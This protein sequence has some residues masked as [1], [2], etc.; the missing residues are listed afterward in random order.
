MSLKVAVVGTGN[1]ARQNYLP[2]LAAQADIALSYYN[3][4]R[5]KA[6]DAAQQFG[7]R[8]ADSFADLLADEPDTVLVLTRE[9]DRA[10][11]FEALLPLRPKRI[12]FEKPLVARHGQANVV[13]EDFFQANV[14]MAAA[15]A[16]GIE[17]AMVFNYR[18]FEQTRQARMMIEQHQLGAPL[19]FSA[20]VHYACWSHCI[21]LILDFVGPARRISALSSGVARPCMGSALATDLSVAVHMENDATGTILGSCQLDFKAPLY[22]LTLVFE[23]G[24]IT[25][26]DLDGDLELLDYASGRHIVH[27]L[28]R[29]RSR[30]DHYR[31]SFVKS[32]E[33]YLAAIRADAPPPVP[34]LAGLRELQ[35]EAAIKRSVAQVRPVVLAEELPLAGQ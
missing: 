25:M 27:G 22:E 33:A 24:R 3:R 11:V 15:E 13:E 4:S 17:T 10:A 28:S 8:V 35:F 9:Q 7:G 5:A 14:L 12:F 32:L 31:A 21:D 1:V 34:G 16:A 19:H 26:R 20:L 2:H 30:W 29:D 18:F 23:R 6:E